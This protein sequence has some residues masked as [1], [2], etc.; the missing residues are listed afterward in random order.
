[1]EDVEKKDTLPNPHLQLL[2]EK[3]QFRPL[4]EQAIHNDPNFQTINGLGLFAHNLQNELYSTNSISKGDLGRK[5]S[6][7]G[8]ELAARV[9]ATLIDR[10]DVDLGYETQNIAAWLRKKGLDAKLKGR[11]RVRF[12]G[13]NETKANNATETWFSQEDFT[14]G[15]LVLAY[16]YLAQKMTEHS[17]L[18]EQPEDKKVLKLAS[19]MASIV[20][21]EIRNI[22]LEGKPLDAD[23][24]TAMLKSPLAEAGMEITDKD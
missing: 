1:M 16:E 10:T 7:S 4:L 6:N 9:P 20:S 11:Q 22:V 18:S 13:G 24:T 15:G 14:P 23:T 19:V 8:I 3:E 12:S 21:E 5:I 17:A 2:Q